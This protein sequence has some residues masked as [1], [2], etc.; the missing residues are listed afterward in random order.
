M[1]AAKKI[2]DTEVGHQDG[3]EGQ[4]AVEVIVGG[5]AQEEQGEVVDGH[6]IDHE[7]DEGPHLLGVP[8][9]IGAPRDIGPDGSYEDAD[10]QAGEGGVE[11]EQ[12]QMAG[13][14]RKR[15][16]MGQQTSHTADEGEREQGE[17]HHDDADVQ[18]E[19]R[20]VEHGHEMAD[21]RVHLTDVGDEQEKARH[22]EPE[23]EHHGIAALHE[24]G[25][26]H[27]RPRHEEHGLVA[28]GH[29][30]MAGDD[31]AQRQTEGK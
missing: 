22:E 15:T 9:P 3:E 26:E 2:V 19:Q 25:D 1:H 5:A 8:A 20:R 30:Y 17:R 13:D 12:R 6:S 16:A 18:A 24:E 7:G 21:L 27:D 4:D 28:V 10:A 14:Q 23:G 11:E 29:G 31:P